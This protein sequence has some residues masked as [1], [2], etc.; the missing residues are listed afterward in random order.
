MWLSD[1]LTALHSSASLRNTFHGSPFSDGDQLIK[2]QLWQTSPSDHFHVRAEMIHFSNINWRYF[3]VWGH[4][5]RRTPNSFLKAWR[6]ETKAARGGARE[7]SSKPTALLALTSERMLGNVSTSP[8]TP[9]LLLL[10]ALLSGGCKVT[11]SWIHFSSFAFNNDL[12][13]RPPLLDGENY[14]I[15]KF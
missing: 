11:P 5:Q 6:Q 7:P 3:R 4:Y 2:T 10:V 12:A 8:A 15:K 13:L 14:S 9:E 1:E